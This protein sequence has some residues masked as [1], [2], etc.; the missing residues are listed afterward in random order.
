MMDT[1]KIGDKVIINLEK[2][3][4]HVR[5]ELLSSFEK[6]S[7]E[8]GVVSLTG[9]VLDTHHGAIYVMY[10]NDKRDP[11]YDV[12]DTASMLISWGV[13]K[14]LLLTMRNK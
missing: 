6:G 2:L 14:K 12:P 11:N 1:F 3:S 10:D 5:Y 7:L 13:A 9:T 8:S 4:E